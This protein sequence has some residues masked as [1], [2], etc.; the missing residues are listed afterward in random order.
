MTLGIHEQLFLSAAAGWLVCAFCFIIIPSWRV[1]DVRSMRTP[2]ICTLLAQCADE[3]KRRSP[4]GAFDD[5]DR[6]VSQLGDDQAKKLASALL[7]DE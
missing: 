6:F 4:P 2:E 3:L 7:R 5:I 1:R